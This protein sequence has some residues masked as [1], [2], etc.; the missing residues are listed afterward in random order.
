METLITSQGLAETF[1]IPLRTLDQWAYQGKGPKFVKVGR[2]RRY[3]PEDID[4]WV[5]DN[6]RGGHHA[7]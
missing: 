1:G 3:R 5:A 4:Q 2:H 6:V 7:A